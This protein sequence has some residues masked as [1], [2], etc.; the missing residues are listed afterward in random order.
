MARIASTRWPPKSCAACS[1]SSLEERS[2]ARASRI[3]G[4]RSGGTGADADGFAAGAGDALAGPLLA[5]AGI[6]SA[7]TRAAEGS[8]P[9]SLFCVILNFSPCM[10]E[11]KLAKI[12]FWSSETRESPRSFSACRR[13]EHPRNDQNIAAPPTVRYWLLG[14]AARRQPPMS[15]L[16][17]ESS[18]G[19]AQTRPT[20]SL[21]AYLRSSFL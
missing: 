3:C 20:A 15:R 16:S 12:D 2:A 14:Y 5:A 8:K 13:K 4:C 1:R 7:S 17:S 6:A 9:N 21:P 11:P 19:P 18:R 10:R